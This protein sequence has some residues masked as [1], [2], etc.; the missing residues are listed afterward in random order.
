VQPDVPRTIKRKIFDV[1]VAKNPSIKNLV[2]AYDG[3]KSFYT[4]K[5]LNLG[6]TAK[7]F[8][9]NLDEGNAKRERIFKI[10]IQKAA[11]IVMEETH[12]YIRGKSGISGNVQAGIQALDVIFRHYPA[13]RHPVLGRSFYT[14]DGC[15]SL[16]GGVEM[17][18]GYFQSI[19]PTAG[20]LMVN[21]DLSA[22]AFY[23]P[24]DLIDYAISVLNLRNPNDISRGL[25]QR[26]F[27]T[28]EKSLKNVKVVTTHRGESTRMYR[29]SK[30]TPETA[31]K[32]TFKLD[33]GSSM[34]VGQYFK[35]TYGRSLRHGNLP[36][37]LVG[38]VKRGIALPMEVCKIVPSQRYIKKLGDKQT[39]SMIKQTAAK[40]QGRRAKTI[41][42][43]KT[44]DYA[45]NPNLKAFHVKVN[46]NMVQVEGRQLPSPKVLYGDRSKGCSDMFV[47]DGAWSLRDKVFYQGASLTHWVVIPFLDSRDVRGPQ[48]IFKFLEVLVRE[49]KMKGINIRQEK[50]LL[51]RPTGSNV[52]GQQV[53]QCVVSNYQR[54]HKVQPEL[55]VFI[56]PFRS[57][58]YHDVKKVCEL[59]FGIPSQGI[60]LNHVF[61]AQPQYCANVA[62]KINVKLGG[63]NVIL[64]KE[65]LPFIARKPTIVFGA[66]VTHPGPGEGSSTPSIAAV[67]ASMNAQAT[68][69]TPAIRVQPSRM[70][71]IGDLENVVFELLRKFYAATKAQPLQILFYRDGVSEGQFK[72]VR[73]G[74]IEAI[75]KA[76]R[77][78]H[79]TYKPSITFLVVQKRHHARFFAVDS[80]DTD[81]S[82]NVQSGLVVDN[83][84]THPTEFDFYLQSHGGLIGTC[85]PAHYHVLHDENKFTADALQSL[86]FN[87]CHLFQRATRIVSYCPPAYY[88]HLV[89]ARAKS[90]VF[91]GDSIQS[92]SQSQSH[93]SSVGA[94]EQPV[95]NPKLDKCMFY[96]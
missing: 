11:E 3:Q 69:Y 91:G 40:P 67:V 54:L 35:K 49:C 86:T 38:D 32:R 42:G 47:K 26:D 85:R 83:G 58:I 70:E 63:M 88:S 62:M 29:I 55:I 52:N 93:Q 89:A 25:S 16:G 22:T 21:V 4:S 90:Y 78:L 30:L 27:A 33:D 60:L 72:A 94:Y 56:L 92:Q 74:E 15:V 43:F 64:P 84:V 36:C 48:D 95:V 19:R 1:F 44:L 53:I 46:E 12:R 80:R 2:P 82:G 20:K 14:R 37:V 50:P 39:A 7:V 59:N 24:K 45:Q 65:A 9:V 5:S 81:R 28:L 73:E 68:M 31:D 8:E 96:M 57:P 75:R 13:M 51:E 79:P 61:K 87:L 6:G 41:E 23:E 34:S 17:W 10:Q 76:C 66:D 77:R 18:R 71:I